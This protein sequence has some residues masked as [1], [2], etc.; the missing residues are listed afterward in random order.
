[1]NKNK[2]MISIE[3]KNEL[4]LNEKKG[5]KELLGK[6][7]IEFNPDNLFLKYEVYMKGTY[8][9][10][11]VGTYLTL[12][13]AKRSIK[14]IVKKKNKIFTMYINAYNNDNEIILE[15]LEKENN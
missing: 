6:F 8:S 11:Y 3:T 13:D 12:H 2:E 7:K 4:T 15:E 5:L 1:M 10:N 14:K 9:C